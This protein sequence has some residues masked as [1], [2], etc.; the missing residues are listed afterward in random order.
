MRQNDNWLEKAKAEG[1]KLVERKDLRWWF[2]PTRKEQVEIFG[3]GILH[4]ALSR[5]EAI[6]LAKD[7]IIPVSGDVYE[8]D[9][10]RHPTE[11]DLKSLDCLHVY[12]RGLFAI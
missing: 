3:V 1:R 9:S 4:E 12:G 5:E 6:I 10:C 2:I 8:W 7:F 11:E